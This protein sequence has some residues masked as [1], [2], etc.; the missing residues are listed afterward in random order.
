MSQ[1]KTYSRMYDDIFVCVH[2]DTWL[3]LECYVCAWQ[4][5][6]L[7]QRHVAML[8]VMTQIDV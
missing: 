1:R 7:A 2:S 6:W 4:I 5:T 8:V 3:T